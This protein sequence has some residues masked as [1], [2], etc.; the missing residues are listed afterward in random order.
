VSTPTY[1]LI[2]P[3]GKQIT[4]SKQHDNAFIINASNF[5][6]TGN[7]NTIKAACSSVAGVGVIVNQGGIATN[8]LTIPQTFNGEAINGIDYGAFYGCS[9]IT[10][11]ALP[12]SINTIRSSAFYGC[13][14]LKEMV[15]PGALSS[16]EDAAFFNCVGIRS[17]KF[18]DSQ[19]AT[20]T[21]FT[22]G[23]NAFKGCAPMGTV[24]GGGQNTQAILVEMKNKAAG[25]MDGWQ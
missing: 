24:S 10:N 20:E 21:D 23:S 14:S 25:D 22:I 6:H 12:I 13:T 4:D 5:D 18:A 7:S 2:G 3:D 19:T 9:G 15:F 8:N 17:Y 11:I 1:Y 16:I